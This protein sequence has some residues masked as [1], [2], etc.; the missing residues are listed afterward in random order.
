MVTVCDICALDLVVY[1]DKYKV[2][3]YFSLY[4]IITSFFFFF[5]I[6]FFL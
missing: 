3:S 2:F 4:K 5:A 1:C 6:F